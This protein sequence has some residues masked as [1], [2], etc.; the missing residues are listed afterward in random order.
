M[1]VRAAVEN[2]ILLVF[3]KYLLGG[4][5][6]PPRITVTSHTVFRSRFFPFKSRLRQ[7]FGARS[8]AR[9]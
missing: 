3:I 1:T 7:S 2:V 9:P 6:A 5:A 8:Y 4:F